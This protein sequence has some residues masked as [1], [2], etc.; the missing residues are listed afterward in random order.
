M[1]GVTIQHP[2]LDAFDDKIIYL[3]EVKHRI[4]TMNPLSDIAWIRVDSK[5]L[6]KELEHII[7]EWIDK[8]SQFLLH[9]TVSRITNMTDFI[10]EVDEG[11]QVIP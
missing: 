9:N 1:A 8:F 7:S 11:I 3:T 4:A 2:D 6:I 5:P 10:T